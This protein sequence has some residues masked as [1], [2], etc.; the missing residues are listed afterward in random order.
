MEEQKKHTVL[1]LTYLIAH[2]KMLLKYNEHAIKEKQSA[3][4]K[5]VIALSW[6]ACSVALCVRQ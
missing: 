6:F 1:F 2:E 5:L 4:E 3:F